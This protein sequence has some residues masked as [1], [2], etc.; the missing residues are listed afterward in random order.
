MKRCFCFAFV[1]ILLLSG[2][3][4]RTGTQNSTRTLKD[5]EVLQARMMRLNESLAQADSGKAGNEPIARWLLPAELAEISGLALTLDGRLFAHQDE[6]ARITEIDYRRGTIKKHFF[7]GEAGLHG[8]F[9]GL[10]YANNRFYM[11]DSKGVLYEF[12]EGAQG[13]RVD[14]TVHDLHLGKECEFEGVAYDAT[15]NSMILSCKNV[16]EK[17][18]KGMLVLYR[19][20]LDVKGGGQISEIT[21]PQSKLI[22][23]NKWKELRPTDITVDPANGNYVLVSAQE[24]A[25]FEVTPQGDPV[26]AMPLNGQHPQAEG[27]AITQ[28]HILIVSDESTNSAATLTLYRWQ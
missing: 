23:T 5:S 14:C 3:C 22:G 17:Q 11:L 8:D 4:R 18:H 24:K 1:A 26:L 21:V 27:L 16:G 12:P 19:Y 20:S 6:T 2:G 15:S 10:T 28:D 25:L 9:E 7:A 13:E